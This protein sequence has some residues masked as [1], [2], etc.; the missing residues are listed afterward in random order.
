[1]E[2]GAFSEEKNEKGAIRSASSFG[3]IEYINKL[4][5]IPI[6]LGLLLIVIGLIK[7]VPG[8]A[9]TTYKE[10]DGVVGTDGY[11]IYNKFSAIDEYVGGDAYNLIIG[12][13]LVGGRIAGSMT[14]KSVFMAGGLI[15]ICIGIMMYFQT[16]LEE[17]RKE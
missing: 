6:V 9:L 4:Y 5:F 16:K 1:M 13:S 17:Q 15:C 11:F 3:K 12:A 10:L 7:E 14:Q 2:K 8:G